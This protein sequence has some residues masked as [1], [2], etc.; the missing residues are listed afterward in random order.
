[1]RMIDQG[2]QNWQSVD[3]SSFSEPESDGRQAGDR[4]PDVTRHVL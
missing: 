4:K 2:D 3:E 1:M